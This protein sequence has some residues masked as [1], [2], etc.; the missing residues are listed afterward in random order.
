MAE[1]ETGSDEGLLSLANAGGDSVTEA[2][3]GERGTFACSVTDGWDSSAE[4]EASEPGKIKTDSIEFPFNKI[5]VLNGINRLIPSRNDNPSNF[6]LTDS[7]G[8]ES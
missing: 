8:R 1:A 4:A 5:T 7:S 3:S 6:L 2:G